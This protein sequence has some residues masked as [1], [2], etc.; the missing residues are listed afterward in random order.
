M[1]ILFFGKL[2]DAIGRM[3]TVEAPSG[4]CTVA[5]LRYLLASLY[6]MAAA[7]LASPSLRACVEDRIV[8]EGFR[9]GADQTVEFFP[10]LSGG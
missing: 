6:P 5:E 10:P 3:V 8:G 1:D 7:D 9:V 2:G 4:G